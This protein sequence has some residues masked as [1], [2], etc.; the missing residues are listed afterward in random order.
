MV[1][2]IHGPGLRQTP[3]EASGNPRAL[4]AGESVVAG[5]PEPEAYHGLE[6]MNQDCA[7]YTY[8]G[9]K[10]YIHIFERVGEVADGRMECRVRI[11]GR[12]QSSHTWM[13]QRH[14]RKAGQTSC[15]ELNM[16]LQILAPDMFSAHV[17][18]SEGIR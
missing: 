2:L 15:S 3:E 13:A 12:T 18:G 7:L 10:G 1:R 5:G 17:C 8:K 16:R 14:S 6:T 4:P 9:L 11:V